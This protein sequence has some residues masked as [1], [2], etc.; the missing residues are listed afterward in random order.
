[1]LG[2]RVGRSAARRRG[3]GADTIHACVKPKSGA[4]R[5]IGSKAKCRHGEQKLSWNTSGARGPA[6][7]NGANGAN[8]AQGPEGKAGANGAGALYATAS[9]EVAIPL[10]AM[11]TVLTKTLPPGS[12][13]LTAKTALV[14]GGPSPG[15][16]DVACFMQ[17]RPGTTGAGEAQVLDEA[18][19][20][21]PMALEESTEYAAD[22][23]LA[24]EGTLTSTVTSTLSMSCLRIEGSVATKAF[25][26]Q[27]GALSVS[28][29]L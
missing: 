26:S 15:Y 9:F 10:E 28:G 21:E 8:G 6:G 18:A 13:A 2:G 29:V 19:W 12:Y 23:T 4:T 17:D 11:Q 14:A 1:V 16:V 27:M 25:F 7:A 3:A 5:I 22:G 24:L 20:V